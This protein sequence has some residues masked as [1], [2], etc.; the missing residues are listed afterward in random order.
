VDQ[1]NRAGIGAG[2]HY[3][4]AMHREPALAAARRIGSLAVAERAAA[5]VLSLPLFPGITVDQ[6]NRVV[7]ELRRALIS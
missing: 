4:T 1:L 5:E 6:Q 7:T 2:I 3:P